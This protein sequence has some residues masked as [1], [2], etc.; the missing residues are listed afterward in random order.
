VRRGFRGLRLG[1][2]LVEAAVA[3]ARDLGYRRM[4][5]DTLPSMAI[6]QALY[7]SL[8]FREIPPYGHH[9]IPGTIFMEL[10]LGGAGGQGA[11]GSST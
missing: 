3:R 11:T 1:R 6:A 10:D 2:Q 7:A 4:R 9:P 5:L 8:G